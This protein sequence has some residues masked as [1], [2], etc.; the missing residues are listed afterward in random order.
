[1]N[2]RIDTRK[3][4]KNLTVKKQNLKPFCCIWRPYGWHT[5]RQNNSSAKQTNVLFIDLY[6]VRRL[7]SLTSWS[8]WSKSLP[9]SFSAVEIIPAR[10]YSGKWSL[11]QFWTDWTHF[12]HPTDEQLL[13]LDIHGNQK[14]FFVCQLSSKAFTVPG[15]YH[16]IF[17]LGVRLK[18][19]SRDI[20]FYPYTLILSIHP[21]RMSER[22]PQIYLSDLTQIQT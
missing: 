21:N 20:H 6:Y 10:S 2:S 16:S 19:L 18:W 7:H 15:S 14:N 8:W 3:I 9:F 17:Y 5:R 1:M 4:S 22:H 11:S 13:Y 12:K